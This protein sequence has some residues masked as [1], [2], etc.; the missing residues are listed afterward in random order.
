MREGEREN[1]RQALVGILW[2]FVEPV[3]M[4]AKACLCKCVLACLHKGKEKWRK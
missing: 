4:V 3:F 2:T 1:E